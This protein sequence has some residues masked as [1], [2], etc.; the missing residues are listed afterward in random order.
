MKQNTDNLIQ[1]MNETALHGGIGK[2]AS[3][4]GISGLNLILLCDIE[5][6]INFAVEF[7]HLCNNNNVR[8]YLKLLWSFSRNPSKIPTSKKVRYDNQKSVQGGKNLGYDGLVTRSQILALAF[9]GV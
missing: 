8:I 4:V 5:Q 1:L 7:L 9:I 2:A 3:G 6:I